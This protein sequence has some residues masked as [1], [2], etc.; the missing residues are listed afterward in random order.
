MMLCASAGAWV[1]CGLALAALCIAT[2]VALAAGVPAGTQIENT[3]TVSYEL[4]G[5][6][7]SIDTNT[8]TLT[9]AERI[10]VVVTRQSPQVLVQPGESN[11][12]ILFRV[13]NNG[14]GAESFSLTINSNLAGNDFNPVPAAAA[15]V[16]DTDGSGDLNTGDV[17]YQPGVNDPVLAADASVD[18]FLVNDIPTGPVNGDIGRTELTATSLTGS[19]APG[20]N[21][22]GQGD[23][24]SDA[25]IG[26]SGGT[27]AEN[28]EYVVADVQI[29]IV[30]A[31]QVADQ[32]GGT[33]PVPGAI[34]T[35][36]VTIEVTSAGI[37]SNAFI[38]DPVPVYTSYNAE[39]ILLN[40]NPLSDA[41]DGDDGEL[42]TSGTTP[43]IVV[44][45]GDLEIGDG[46]QVVEFQV[47]IN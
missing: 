39:S 2:P 5:S 36:T 37:A 15:I 17:P 35:Y 22:P 27:A 1:R 32:F 40:G 21:L 45:L 19:G 46:P 23:G 42:D 47:T 14:N 3:A 25:V 4:S 7:V 26:T 9:V 34:V 20:T 11:R 10:D 43:T 16:F 28:G 18:V 12:A 33:E 24:G 6:T 8:A 30:K 44:R 38:R 13:T 31:Q 29:S 41:A